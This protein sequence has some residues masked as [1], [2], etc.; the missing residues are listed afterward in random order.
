MYPITV[1]NF[2]ADLALLEASGIVRRRWTPHDIA[3]RLDC[4]EMFVKHDVVPD[5]EGQ[6]WKPG[7]GRAR[8]LTAR[9]GRRQYLFEG[10]RIPTHLQHHIEGLAD[11]IGECRK[12]LAS[13]DKAGATATERIETIN[14]LVSEI[15]LAA[16]DHKMRASQADK[17]RAATTERKAIAAD[18]RRQV[19]ELAAKYRRLSQRQMAKRIAPEIVRSDPNDPGNVLKRWS[20]ATIREDLRAIER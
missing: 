3:K 15:G 2:D 4:L 16:L 19:A 7:V 12:A 13:G 1:D 8:A 10:V 18:R 9:Y 14:R 20:V 17:A 6:R 5:I 11:A